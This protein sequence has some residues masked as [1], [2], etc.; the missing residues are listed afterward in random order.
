MAKFMV[1]GFVDATVSALVDADTAEDAA[2]IGVDELPRPG[3]CYQCSDK[4]E[5]G[6]VYRVQ[7]LA[8]G[9]AGEVEYDDDPEVDATVLQLEIERL[10]KELAKAKRALVANVK[11]TRKP[12]KKGT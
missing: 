4:L 2:D 10:T 9:G 3:V 6:E 1:R 7:V 11:G 5:V 12:R 8:N